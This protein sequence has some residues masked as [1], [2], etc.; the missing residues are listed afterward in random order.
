MDAGAADLFSSFGFT[1]LIDIPT[2]V[3]KDTTSLI[4][5]IFG[6]NTD[7]VKSHGTLPKIA[8]HNAKAKATS[9]AALVSNSLFGWSLLRLYQILFLKKG[10]KFFFQIGNGKFEPFFGKIVK[11]K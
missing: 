2:R 5:L 6:R 4:D 10:I 3:T 11:F 1:R 8:D 9:W 7:N